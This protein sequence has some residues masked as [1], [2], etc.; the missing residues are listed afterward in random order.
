MTEP[1]ATT[2]AERLV[3]TDRVLAVLLELGEHPNG[4]TLDVLASVIGSPKPTIHRALTALR[5]AGLARLLSRG[6][7]VLGDEFL[8]IAFRT[9]AERPESMRV[10]PILERLAELY[11]ETVHY[12]VLDGA[13]VVYRAKTDPPRGAV[14]LT[15]VIGGRNPAYRTAVGKLLLSQSIEGPNELEALLGKAPLPR[16]TPR[17]IC[18]IDALWSELETTR[19]RGYA[20]DDQENEDGVNCVAVPL[21]GGP[22]MS[23]PGAVSVSALAF[24]LPLS[25]LVAE[26]PN[27]LAVVQD[28]S[29]DF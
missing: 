29:P 16:R 7:Y 15:S 19:E 11:G 5:K 4:V 22:A 24:R 14:R 28:T 17:T 21:N 3:G 23:E 9:V 13:E 1:S 2:H 26:V 10:R 25:A 6:H 12:A 8:R 27:I 18:D 20:V